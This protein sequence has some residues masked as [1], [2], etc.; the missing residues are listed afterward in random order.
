MLLL[1]KWYTKTDIRIW[2][3]CQLL[4]NLTIDFIAKLAIREPFSE[5]PTRL[6]KPGRI[7][8]GCSTLFAISHEPLHSAEHADGILVQRPGKIQQGCSEWAALP[9]HHLAHG[10]LALKDEAGAVRCKVL[11]SKLRLDELLD[12]RGEILR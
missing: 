9:N 1:T 8:T 11:L 6:F 10:D 2:I 12:V 5:Q 4:H 3:V 7:R